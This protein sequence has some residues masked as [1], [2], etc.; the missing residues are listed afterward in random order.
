[1]R[2]TREQR[3]EIKKHYESIPEQQVSP[4]VY[5]QTVGYKYITLLST[6]DKTHE[7]KTCL[8]CFEAGQ[9][10]HCQHV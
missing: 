10:G 5:L 9:W 8:D 6:W 4:G 7:I 2:I 3:A 1:M